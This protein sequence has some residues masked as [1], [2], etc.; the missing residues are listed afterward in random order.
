MET[1]SIRD[2]RGKSLR[3]K[4]LN[5]KPVAI[6]NRGALIGVVIPVAQAWVEHLIDYNWSHVRQSIAEGEQELTR[7]APMTTIQDVLDAPDPPA[8]DHSREEP[9]P[10]ESG[11][12]TVHL[13]AALVGGAISQSP[14]TSTMIG[15]LQ[16][17]L[18]PVASRQHGL[19]AEPSVRTVRIGS[20]T[21]E[22]IEQAGDAGQTLAVT[23][24]RELIGIVIPVTRHLVEFLIDQNISRILYNI[25]LSEK[26]LGAPDSGLMTIDQIVGPEK[27]SG[28]GD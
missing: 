23:H 20:L 28:L 13:A 25:G 26:Q 4:A 15:R 21:A 19:A 10:G 24:D 3:E 5:G 6:T 16:S 7:D 22:L 9:A 17:L 2:L 1:V 11:G 27:P 8:E 14:Q 12:P 18:N